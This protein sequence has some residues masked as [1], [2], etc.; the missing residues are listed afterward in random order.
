MYTWI[1]ELQRNDGWRLL[2][3]GRDVLAGGVY[4]RERRELDSDG[5]Q[6]WRGVWYTDGCLFRCET[7]LRLS[8]LGLACWIPGFMARIIYFDILAR[9]VCYVDKLLVVVWLMLS[10]VYDRCFAW[11]W[12]L[13]WR[14]WVG[15]DYCLDPITWISRTAGCLH[16]VTLPV[17]V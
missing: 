12:S 2:S 11:S 1:E 9:I 13:A 10:R 4:W 14:N 16:E 5:D 8:R 6:D 7:D 15:W 3:A 17:E